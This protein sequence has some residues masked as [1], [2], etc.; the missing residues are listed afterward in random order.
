MTVGRHCCQAVLVVSCCFV[1]LGSSNA[2]SQT[3][4]RLQS[5]SSKDKS[6]ERLYFLAELF[7]SPKLTT[8]PEDMEMFVVKFDTGLVYCHST[9]RSRVRS[10]WARLL[11]M[12]DRGEK[13]TKDETLM[14]AVLSQIAVDK[15]PNGKWYYRHPTKLYIDFGKKVKGELLYDVLKAIV[16]DGSLDDTATDD[17][18]AAINAIKAKRIRLIVFDGKNTVDP[19]F[20]A[21]LVER[22][23][24]GALRVGSV[25][26]VASIPGAEKQHQRALEVLGSNKTTDFAEC[27]A[28]IGGLGDG[29]I[30]I[31]T[32]F[33]PMIGDGKTAE[34]PAKLM[35]RGERSLAFIMLQLCLDHAV[36]K[37]DARVHPWANAFAK[38]MHFFIEKDVQLDNADVPQHVHRLE[39]ATP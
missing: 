38:Q 16:V 7:L 28:Y 15:L 34:F 30:Y 22:V 1:V 2:M 27:K 20:R 21:D 10:E 23:D 3:I 32:N 9:F 18:A 39:P 12:N 8:A 6:T 13:L 17:L 14:V 26:D 4:C 24:L 36:K 35:T 11:D 33:L 29:R 19:E 31:E 37:D 25:V 5:I